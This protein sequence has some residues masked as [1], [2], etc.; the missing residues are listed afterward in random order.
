MSEQPDL[1]LLLDW[2]KRMCLIRQFEEHAIN[3]FRKGL[4]S[5]STHPCIGQEAIAVGAAAGLELT[6]YGTETRPTIT[7]PSGS[8]TSVAHQVVFDIRPGRYPLHGRR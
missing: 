3:S 4:F 7:R 8:S 1:D 6:A 5:G 2:Y